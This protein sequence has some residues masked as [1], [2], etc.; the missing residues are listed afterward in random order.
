MYLISQEKPTP[1]SNQYLELTSSTKP[2]KLP[3]I[4]PKPVCPQPRL[5]SFPSG[6]VQEFKPVKNRFK[7]FDFK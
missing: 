2:F 5:Q 6:C 3:E 7:C 4:R 1:C